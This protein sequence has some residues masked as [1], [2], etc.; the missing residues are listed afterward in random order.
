MLEA[1]GG[2]AAYRP[3]LPFQLRQ[4][5]TYTVAGS[6]G[7]KLGNATEHGRD[8]V[9]HGHGAVNAHVEDVRGDGASLPILCAGE[10]IESF[11]E[12]PVILG[13]HDMIAALE[14]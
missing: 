10:A 11:A 9:E 4:R 2:D 14:S 1:Q 6:L 12:S 13:E 8:H 7:L 3:S 5:A